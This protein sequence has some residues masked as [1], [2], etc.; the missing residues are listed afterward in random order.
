[1]LRTP[2]IALLFLLFASS[3]FAQ[4]ELI[5]KLE[6]L[7][8]KIG[9]GK[10]ESRQAAQQE[11]LKICNTMPK[12]LAKSR[13][14]VCKAIADMVTRDRTKSAARIFL[15]KQLERLGGEESVSVLA[16]MLDSEQKGVREAARRALANNPSSK[17]SEVL[18]ARFKTAEGLQA[19]LIVQAL[20]FRQDKQS[21]A[22]L[23][24]I[25]E[26]KKGPLVVSAVAALSNA[27][28]AGDPGA[29]LLRK[30]Y[31]KDALLRLAD[32]LADEGRTK[33]ALA[34]FRPIAN[35]QPKSGFGAAAYRG[36]LEHDKENAAELLQEGLSGEKI[37]RQVAVGFLRSMPD[38][39]A[40]RL[41]GKFDSLS[42][43]AQVALLTGLGER[44]DEEFLPH[45]MKALRSPSESV[46]LAGI[47]ALGQLKAVTPLLAKM[48]SDD[49]QTAEAAKSSIMRM[50]GKE[51]DSELVS[52]AG[53]TT[54]N[55]KRQVLFDILN[56]RR[57]VDALPLF[58]ASLSD[59]DMSIRQKS[60]AAVTRLGGNE[61]ISDLLTAVQKLSGSERDRAEK[62]VVN[63]S[64]RLPDGGKPV[65]AFY[66]KSSNSTK[67]ELLPLLGRIGGENS[68][69]TIR[70]GLKSEDAKMVDASITAMSNWPDGSVSEDLQRVAGS[71]TS[72]SRKIRV[73]RALARVGVLGG[74]DEKRLGYLKFVMDN[75]TRK[76]EKILALD[77]AKAV[78]TVESL[79]FVLPH[80]KDNELGP[81]AQRTVVDLAHH[82]GLR[83]DNRAD[84]GPA[85]KQVIRLLEDARQIE[86]A[87]KYLANE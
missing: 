22:L 7:L 80:I 68:L 70:A 25:V 41:L 46:R 56:G 5:S 77:R 87:K 9:K 69:D 16:K 42:V 78:R 62:Q 23:S 86:R 61:Q 21:V 66:D 31:D 43:D 20:G 3:V 39:V 12:P 52:L 60:F 26:Q 32:R 59:S 10:I 33:A 75:A 53:R 47:E 82:R 30:G 6:Q 38:D 71:T 44:T 14:H 1:M 74:E 72:T 13:S 2:Q 45:V 84:F 63:M 34:I 37:R 51:V 8:P 79:R 85:L 24:E 4:D 58:V 67:L 19:Q 73:L 35:N 64:R 50:R 15:L 36:L 40:K 17:A 29:K 48:Q 11:W 65:V 83:E 76:D 27:V 55:S 81:R 57:V 54:D 49:S 18:V 28:S